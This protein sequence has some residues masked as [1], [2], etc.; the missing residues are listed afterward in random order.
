MKTKSSAASFSEEPDVGGNELKK[1][2]RRMP[3]AE[4]ERHGQAADGEHAE[5]FRQEKVRVLEPGIFGHV[6]G[7][8]FRFT[9]RDIEWGA[10]RFHETGDE[11]QNEGRR[12][13]GR[14]DEPA[15][16]DAGQD[17][18]FLG[19]D[20]CISRERADDHDDGKHGN[21]ERQLVA[22]HLRDRAHR[23]QHRE[24]IVASPAGHENA[25]LGRRSDGEEKQDAAIDRERRHVPAVGNDAE[26]QDRRGGNHDRR[27]EMDDLIGAKRDDVFLDQELDAVRQR[28]EK[29]ERADA[30]WPVTVLDA[31]ENLPLEDGH[32][33]EERHEHA[34]ERGDVKETRSDLD[35][36]VRRVGQEREEP[37]LCDNEDL[38][39]TLADHLR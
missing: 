17:V 12:T 16:H 5:V 23:A 28:L 6:S 32:E 25:E 35:H 19:R 22:D 36:P 30:I 34:E 11:E 1:T 13:P 20:D 9:L 39:N 31:R 26:G 10:V 18:A 24:F 4:K 21:N 3:A 7:D 14:E 38:V 29:P 33:G 37:M 27:D 2:D 15:R 8:N